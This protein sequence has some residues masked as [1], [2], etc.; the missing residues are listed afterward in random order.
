MIIYVFTNELKGQSHLRAEG[1]TTLNR[2][3]G[4]GRRFQ[5]D[6]H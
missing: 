2:W 5:T 4:G 6:N 3:G 1:P